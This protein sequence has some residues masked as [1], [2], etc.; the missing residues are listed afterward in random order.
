MSQTVQQIE[1]FLKSQGYEVETSLHSLYLIK[2]S[3]LQDI[4]EIVVI[5][6]EIGARAGVVIGLGV[7]ISRYRREER[8]LHISLVIPD[9]PAHR[10]AIRA[11]SP[12]LWEDL[13]W[14]DFAFTSGVSSQ[15]SEPLGPAPEPAPPL[16]TS[17]GSPR[18]D[19]L[20]ALLLRPIPANEKL[21]VQ[22]WTQAAVEMG[23]TPRGVNGMVT[24]VRLVRTL[25]LRTDRP[26]EEL[27]G[28]AARALDTLS[29]LTKTERRSFVQQLRAHWQRI[30]PGWISDEIQQQLLAASVLFRQEQ[31]KLKK[32]EKGVQV[33]GP[34]MQRLG[35]SLPPRARVVDAP[36]WN[37]T[38]SAPSLRQGKR[39]Q[40]VRMERTSTRFHSVERGLDYE[41]LELRPPGSIY[42]VLDRMRR[43]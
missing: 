39:K 6:S 27:A 23:L 16:V 19:S 33:V 13:P 37:P 42:S 28:E 20:T 38:P 40:N 21:A 15:S 24:L 26:F 4:W 22:E 1:S 11:I 14:L 32:P 10:L 36:E 7:A 35:G 43:R 9:T 31:G 12:H 17:K 41:S 18:T 8:P 5:D 30:A 29:Q 3:S 25:R 2:G 34:G